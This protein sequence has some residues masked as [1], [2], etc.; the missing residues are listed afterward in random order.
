MLLL[1]AGS[2]IINAT[3]IITLEVFALCLK[4]LHNQLQ[5]SSLLT[6]TDL[7]LKSCNKIF[8]KRYV[9]NGTRQ[10]V[11]PLEPAR[12]VYFS[13]ALTESCLSSQMEKRTVVTVLFL[14]L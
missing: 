8:S 7:F 12:L 11:W 2:T 9:Y 5:T 4:G 1:G 10:C 14:L 13:T 3:G 6:S